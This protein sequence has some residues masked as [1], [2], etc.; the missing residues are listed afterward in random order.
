MNEI[1][2]F[3]HKYMSDMEGYA[4]IDREIKNLTEKRNVFR[5]NLL[6]AMEK[7]DVKSIDNDI[8]KIT[9]VNPSESTTVDLKKFEKQ[10][11]VDYAQL[12][13]DYPK[14]TKRKGSIR[15]TVKKEG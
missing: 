15:I 9:R 6:E 4:V 11:P 5:D 14:I 13:E 2:R 8:V 1:T 3:D 12:I 7:Y 10:E